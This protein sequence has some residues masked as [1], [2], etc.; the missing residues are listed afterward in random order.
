MYQGDDSN[1]KC[2]FKSLNCGLLY[3]ID[4]AC[5][6]SVCPC[7]NVMLLG[8]ETAEV[9]VYP[10]SSKD[11][12]KPISHRKHV[13]VAPWII[14]FKWFRHAVLTA[15]GKYLKCELVFRF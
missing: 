2:Y 9:G 8:D 1:M 11:I 10:S 15:A 14:V 4:S 6:H 12:G 3:N 5:M 13:D 7:V